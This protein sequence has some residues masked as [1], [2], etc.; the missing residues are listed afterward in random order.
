[1]QMPCFM[2]G[3]QMYTDGDEHAPEGE[4]VPASN[5]QVLQAVIIEHTVID[6]FAGSPFLIKI[7]ILLRIPW[8]PGMETQVG[9]VFDIDCAPIIP[10]G[11]ILRV[12]AGGNTSAF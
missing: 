5:H 4:M 6:P 12:R 11:A 7:L 9:M 10:R 2:P 1:M 8:E 3:I